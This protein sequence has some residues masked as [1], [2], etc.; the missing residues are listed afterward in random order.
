VLGSLGQ[1]DLE[2]LRRHE[3]AHARRPE[4]LQA[5]DRTLALSHSP[6]RER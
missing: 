3:S 5:I 1:E 2:A 4:V 6:E